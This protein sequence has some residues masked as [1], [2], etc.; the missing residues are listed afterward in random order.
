MTDPH[1][2]SSI[3]PS[4]PRP[5]ITISTRTALLRAHQHFAAH[6]FTI[7]SPLHAGVSLGIEWWLHL[8]KEVEAPSILDCGA[9]ASLAIEALHKGIEGVVCRDFRAGLPENMKGRLFSQRPH[10]T[11]IPT[12]IPSQR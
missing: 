4:F 3:F 2:A 11:T 7:V 10:E 5:F 6:S 9:S 1:S 8:T 12:L